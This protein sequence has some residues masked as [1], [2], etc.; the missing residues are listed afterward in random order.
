M[1]GVLGGTFDPI[2][3]GHLRP[4]LD[5]LQALRLDQ[6]RLIPLSVAV[7]RAQPVAAAL[8][9][10]EMVQ[11]AVQG[12]PGL[13]VD[14]R[15]LGRPGGSYSYDTLASLRSELGPE[16]PICFLTGADA[17]REFL[18]W[19]RPRDILGLAHLVVMERPGAGELA[20]PA[21]RR[22]VA[23]RRARGRAELAGAPAG[24]ILCQPVTA[25]D[26]SATGIRD[27]LA[28]GLSPRYL[29]PDAVLDYIRR[30]G[31]YGG[32]ESAPSSGRRVDRRA[33]AE[34]C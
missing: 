8:Q 30:E 2:H 19:H 22:L 9:R 3:H 20:D 15:E 23:E 24:R 26:I 13:A 16:R 28:R 25:L 6:V 17:F 34:R 18:T 4:A 14:D 27:L 5:V 32:D 29:L 31:L 1:I 11:A 33:G 12:E 7:H 10:L 21:L